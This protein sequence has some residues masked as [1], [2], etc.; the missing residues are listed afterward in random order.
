VSDETTPSTP[1]ILAEKHY[2]A[3]D[4]YRVRMRG[5]DIPPICALDPIATW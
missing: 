2:A 5:G 1:P 4:G 3:A